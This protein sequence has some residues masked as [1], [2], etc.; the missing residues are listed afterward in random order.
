MSIIESVVKRASIITRRCKILEEKDVTRFNDNSNKSAKHSQ[1]IFDSQKYFVVCRL[2]FWSA[3]YH[4][5]SRH[6]QRKTCKDIADFDPRISK[7]CC[8]ICKGDW[9]ELFPVQDW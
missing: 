4:H 8:P 5:Y 9:I 1:M 7:L 6:K 3:Y 2:C